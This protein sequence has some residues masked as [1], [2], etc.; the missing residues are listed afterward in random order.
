MVAA[1]RSGAGAL[2]WLVRVALERRRGLT[3]LVSVLLLIEYEA[4]MG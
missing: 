1:I 2:R 4:V 3:L